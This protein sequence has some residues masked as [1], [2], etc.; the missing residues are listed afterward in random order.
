MKYLRFKATD[1]LRFKEFL[2]GLE[3]GVESFMTEDEVRISRRSKDISVYTKNNNIS[4]RNVPFIISFIKDE[5]H[6]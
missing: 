3:P 1:I 4:T 6:I 5:L 2:E